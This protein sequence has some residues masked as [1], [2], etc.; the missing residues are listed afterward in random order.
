MY[1][2]F[3][4]NWR[5]IL[6]LSNFSNYIILLDKTSQK[7]YNYQ[8]KTDITPFSAQEVHQMN[9]TELAAA[10]ATDSDLT[11]KYTE[12]IFICI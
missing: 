8:I 4:I 12:K 2:G 7:A 5:M 1:T 6:P 10:I 11:K 3:S 9:K